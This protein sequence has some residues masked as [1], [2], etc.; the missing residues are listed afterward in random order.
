MSLL[1]IQE[2]AIRLR[3]TASSVYRLVNRGLLQ[4]IRVGYGRGR[5]RIE[6]TDLQAYLDAQRTET[7]GQPRRHAPRL[8][9]KHLR[10]SIG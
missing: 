7:A 2:T 6:E 5:L 10:S 8:A 9:L 4:A 1:T 3:L